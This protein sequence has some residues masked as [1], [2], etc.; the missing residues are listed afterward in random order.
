MPVM[1]PHTIDDDGPITAE[2]NGCVRCHT[3]TGKKLRGAPP[4]PASHVA[5]GDGTP[6]VHG[7]RWNCLLCHAP[8]ADVKPVVA[9]TSP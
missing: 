7:K 2:K 4:V 1:I 6:A 3:A 5:S 8:Q 9:N